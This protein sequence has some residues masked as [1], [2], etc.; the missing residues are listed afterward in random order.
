LSTVSSTD[1]Y[2][3][4]L[5]I[6]SSSVRALLFDSSARQVEGYGARLPTR[7]ET[8]PDGGAEINPE[9]LAGAVID[10]LDELH[11]QIH[12]D[13][14]KI[15]AIASSAFWHGLLGIDGQ[16]RPAT[17]ILH[18]LD[19]R[20]AG[21]VPKVPDAH[22]RTG[23]IPHSSYWPAKLLWLANARPAEF[24]ATRHWISFPEYLFQK[25]FGKP[26]AST[27]MVSGSGLWNQF[28]NDY[29]DETLRAIHVNRSTLIS[30]SGLDQPAGGL[31]PEFENLWPAFHKAPWYP[32]LGDGACDNIGSGAIGPDRFALMVGT[33]GALRAVIETPCRE[34]PQGLWCYRADRKRF[35]MG[36]AMSDGGDVYAWMKRTLALPR[37]LESRLESA[38]PGSHGLT[39]LPFF[40]GERSPDWRS[41]ARATIAGITLATDPFDI[42][43]AGL[44][45][46][47]I[48]FREIY[49][50]LAA[51]L[52]APA[53]ILASGGALLN[54]PAWTQMTADALSRPVTVCTEPEASSRGAALWALEQLGTIP[55][56]TALPASTGATF[57]PLP[58]RE[59]I[60]ARLLSQR[61]ALFKK[62][63]L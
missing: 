10:C 32:S 6:G 39:V 2:I 50:L 34:I 12:A 29:D 36:G 37:D 19:T 9:L 5:D 7:L 13:S 16:G 46:V 14:L 35:V 23:C 41:D 52:G 18:L 49:E 22:S 43:R 42:F 3:V 61:R 21:E 54:S 45:S 47:A 27:S 25:L 44:E 26:C 24:A 62:L 11:R 15:A 58:G 17:P 1:H 40:S 20:S 60:Y 51:A 57:A 63:Y 38:T 8:T 48:E 59:P 30:P 28:T 4:S 56:L 55:D 53:E 31:L 33:T